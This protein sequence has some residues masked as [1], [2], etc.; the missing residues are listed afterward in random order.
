MTQ[1]IRIE[2]HD[3]IRTISL[4][5]GEVRNA[6]DEEMIAALGAAFA[7]A[8]SDPSVR[9]VVLAA[10]G[11]AFCAGADL[12]WM[13][14]MATFSDAE[15]LRDARGLADM[16]Q[17]IYSCPKPTIA[18]VQGDCY[19]GGMGLVAACDMAVA[20]LLSSSACPKSDWA[21]SLPPSRLTWCARWN[22]LRHDASC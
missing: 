6:F 3:A 2:Q 10:D 4:A 12:S 20:S 15:N 5:R 13:K 9:V 14:R 18:R 16:L 19:A 22:A 7:D 1:K 8:G 11:K 17:T 21:S